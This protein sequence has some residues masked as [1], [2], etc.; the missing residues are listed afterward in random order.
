[1]KT[2]TQ[3]IPLF[4]LYLIVGLMQ[5]CQSGKESR[6]EIYFNNF[7]ND[8]L[9]NISG[10][11]FYSYNQTK[12]LGNYN[13]DGFVFYMNQLPAHQM[14]EVSFDLYIHDSW[15]GNQLGNGIDGPDIWALYVDEV[16]YIYTTFSNNSCFYGPFCPPQSYPGNYPQ[17]YHNPKT[18]AY[19]TGLPPTCNYAHLPYGSTIYKIKK[20]VVHQSGQ[21]TVSC[22]DQLIQTNAEDPLCDES[23]SIDNLKISL[24]N[25]ED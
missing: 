5:A 16:P 8:N 20:T 14:V 6:T 21:L 13:K 22:R 2:N 25:Y 3:S 7:E 18:G 9:S 19:Q 1:M 24:I 15:D 4:L 17:N 10:G 23:W 11:K 12:M